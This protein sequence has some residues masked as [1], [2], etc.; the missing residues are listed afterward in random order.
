M[1]RK[2]LPAKLKIDVLTEAGYRC[3]IP[4]CRMTTT[5]IA[6]IEPWSKV[7]EH[8]FENLIA[9][10]PTCHTRYDKGEIKKQSI[11]E[12]KNYLRQ[13]TFIPQIS[14]QTSR[15]H[16]QIF[17]EY[18]KNEKWYKEFVNN[19]EIWI[20]EKDNLYQIHERDDRDEFSEPWTQVYPDKLGSGQSS[21]DLVYNNN[22][23]KRFTFIYCDGGR[24]NVVMPEVEAD[25]NN[26]WEGKDALNGSYKD[27]GYFWVSDSLGV[28]LTRLIGSFYIY[29]NIEGVANRSHIE[30]R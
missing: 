29:K 16:L 6:H 25:S 26:F 5:E 13:L 15:S 20:C 21:V 1:S 18:I 2:A 28:Q 7:K 22:H 24:I 19:K 14:T 4:T 11:Y 30:M 27:I 10:C 3:A 17:E 12:Y 9:L 8:R 23:I